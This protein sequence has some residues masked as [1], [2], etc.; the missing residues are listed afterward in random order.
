MNYEIIAL[1][2]MIFS[3]LG[4]V[5][6]VG[7][8]VPDIIT[9]PNNPNFIPG[10]DLKEKILRELKD[11]VKKNYFEIQLFVQK[12]LYKIRII[13]LRLDNK[14]FNLN[15]KLKEKSRKTKEDID[16]ELDDIKNRLKK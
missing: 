1:V 4:M 13:I 10:R 11:I 7:R 2:V 14:I 5:V 15:L 9:L 12:R 16:F 8:K 3:F 6:I